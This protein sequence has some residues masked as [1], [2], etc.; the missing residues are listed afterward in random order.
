MEG[1]SLDDLRREDS[2]SVPFA[3]LSWTSSADFPLDPRGSGVLPASPEG[4]RAYWHSSWPLW[5]QSR[6][7]PPRKERPRVKYR[8]AMPSAS[9]AHRVRSSRRSTV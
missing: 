2:L 6:F 8:N 1:H 9:L 5:G 7:P 4:S 3:G